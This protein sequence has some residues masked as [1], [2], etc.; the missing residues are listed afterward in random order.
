MFGHGPTR[1]MVLHGWFGDSRI[2]DPLL[3]VLDPDQFTMAF[4]DSPGYG[5]SRD[6]AG[7][8]DLAAVVKEVQVLAD[9]LEW[10]DFSV[11]GHSM[12]GKAALLL[13]CTAAERVCRILTMAPIWAGPAPFTPETFSLF[14]GAVNSPERRAQIVVNSTGGELPDI[15]VKKLVA[16]SLA[17]STTQAFGDYLQ[18]WALDD[19]SSRA[20]QI[21]Q[22]VLIIAGDHDLIPPQFFQDTWLATLPNAQLHSLQNAGHWPMQE[23]PLLVA[24][25]LTDF[26]I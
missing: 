6:L 7:P 23:C 13:A 20:G 16:D 14:Q 1:V 25:L 19:F 5:E 9:Q 24:R 3:P 8:Y 18:S 12:G 21:T 22:E 10:D 17:T 15:W 2:F 26:L 11:M 4:V